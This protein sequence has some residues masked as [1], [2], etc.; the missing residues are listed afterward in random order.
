MNSKAIA[1]TV[2]QVLDS[3]LRPLL[4][5]HGG[6]VRVADVTPEGC[7]HLE[8]LGACHGCNLQ[9]VTHFI[10]VQNR[11]QEINGVSEVVTPGVNVSEAAKRRIKEAYKGEHPLLETQ[12]SYE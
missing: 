4:Q 6:D 5:F 8:Y 1:Q 7:V 9:V 2:Q 12:E 11:L 10:T 3:D